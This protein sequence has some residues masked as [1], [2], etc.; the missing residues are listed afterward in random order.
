MAY[1]YAEKE[2][3]VRGN[4]AMVDIYFD[5]LKYTKLEETKADLPASL[6]SDVGGQLGLWLGCS[7]LTLVELLNFVCVVVPAYVMDK[8]RRK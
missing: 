7:I 8:C 3:A 5:D 2:V 6:V 1:S 4:L